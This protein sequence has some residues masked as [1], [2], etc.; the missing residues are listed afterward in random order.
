MPATIVTHQVGT[1]GPWP[2]QA[3]PEPQGRRVIITQPSGRTVAAY[4]LGVADGTITDAEIVQ[5][6]G[7]ALQGAALMTTAEDVALTTDKT[8]TDKRAVA[9][10]RALSRAGNRLAALIAKGAGNL[11]PAEQDLKTIYTI[12]L[13]ADDGE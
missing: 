5:L 10:V 7:T 6:R 13:S 11:T 4:A 9:R 3:V 1:H 2:I 8:A 12:L